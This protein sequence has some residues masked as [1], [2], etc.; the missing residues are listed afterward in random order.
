MQN[1]HIFNFSN[2]CFFWRVGDLGFKIKASLRLARVG[3]S[4]A[5]NGLWH[6]RQVLSY[7]V[8][9]RIRISFMIVNAIESVLGIKVGPYKLS[10]N[11]DFKSHLYV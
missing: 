2:P 1:V 4:L 11:F 6:C 3:L 8:Y 10:F 5:K 7:K 9:I